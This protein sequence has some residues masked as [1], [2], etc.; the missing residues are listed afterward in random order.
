[1]ST[2]VDTSGNK[3]TGKGDKTEKVSFKV[4]ESKSTND[5][6]SKPQHHGN[7]RG[8]C[9]RAFQKPMTRQPRFQGKCDDLKGYIYDCSDSRQADVYTK[10]TK[11]IGEYVGRTYRHGSD[12]RRAVHTLAM[13]IM[14]VPAYPAEPSD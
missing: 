5:N 10:T 14:I 3:A 2:N 7:Q 8:N 12:A 13:P 1:M 11:E 9:R 4:P 6:T